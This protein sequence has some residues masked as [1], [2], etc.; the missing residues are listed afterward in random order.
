MEIK[1][2]LLAVA[3]LQSPARLGAVT[4]GYDG[5]VIQNQI[6]TWV[7][8]NISPK[9]SNEW[10]TGEVIKISLRNDARHGNF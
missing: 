4:G 7:L 3:K 5:E 1:L 8:I 6:T 2:V 10:H 9:Y